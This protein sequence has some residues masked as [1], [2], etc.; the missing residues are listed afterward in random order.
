MTEIA[1][2]IPESSHKD[3]D[4]LPYPS[5]PP[6]ILPSHNATVSVKREKRAPFPDDQMLPIPMVGA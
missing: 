1:K 5:L 3:K 2:V 6:M 4:I